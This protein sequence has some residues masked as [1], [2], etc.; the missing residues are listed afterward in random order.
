MQK[1][2]IVDFLKR[3]GV[4]ESLDWARALIAMEQKYLD[5][6]VVRQTL[7]CILKHQDDIQ[8]FTEEIWDDQ[9][10]RN[11]YLSPLENDE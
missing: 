2:R 1:I 11:E 4:S 9:E 8:R 7:G 5:Q 3:P 10:K 6:D